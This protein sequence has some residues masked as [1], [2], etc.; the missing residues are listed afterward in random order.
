MPAAVQNAANVLL[1]ASHPASTLNPWK[2][3]SPAVLPVMTAFLFVP[4]TVY[5]MGYPG[6]Q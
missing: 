3:I 6:R 1:H 2:L 5:D 4:K